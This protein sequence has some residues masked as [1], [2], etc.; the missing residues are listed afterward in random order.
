[1]WI[2]QMHIMISRLELFLGTM[3]NEVYKNIR[4]ENKASVKMSL[5]LVACLIMSGPEAL[6]VCV[7]WFLSFLLLTA[8]S[9]LVY[10]ALPDHNNSDTWS[11]TVW[12]FPY[13]FVHI[14]SNVLENVC[15]ESVS[16]TKEISY[17]NMLSVWE[18]YFGN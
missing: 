6:R 13:A 7:K 1:M 10:S 18:S 16:R 14:R 4:C 15:S 3:L 2:S 12:F 8:V 11:R 17:D 5:H 9:Q